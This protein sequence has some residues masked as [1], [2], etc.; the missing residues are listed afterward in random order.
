[1][2]HPLHPLLVHLPLGLWPASVV[3]DLLSRAD[4]GG[5]A[6]VR[7]SFWAIVLGLLASLLAAATGLFDW[8]KIKKEKPARKIGLLH[9]GLNLIV[10]ALFVVDAKI[11]LPGFRFDSEVETTPLVFSIIATLLLIGSAWLGGLM[12]YDQGIGVARGSKKKW[13]AVA[14]NAGA[15]VP[16]EK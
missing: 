12:V 13:R 15:N 6:M 10:I 5:N 4:I 8:L 14:V 3:F 9:M 1:M 7:L 11:R 16:E 2:K